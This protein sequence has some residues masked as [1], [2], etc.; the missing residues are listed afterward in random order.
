MEVEIISATDNK[1]LDRKEINAMLH[2]EGTTPARKE[3]R[4]AVS[5][6]LGLNPELTVLSSVVNEFGAKRIRV[7][8]HAYTDIRKLKEVEPG[9]IR[10]RD[11]VAPPEEKKKEEKAPAKKQ[12]K[13]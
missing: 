8:A 11:N 1:L 4:E 6:K 13:K 7:V 3:I 9:Y 10:K 2:F 5:T 12:E